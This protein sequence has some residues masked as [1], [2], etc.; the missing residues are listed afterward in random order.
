MPIWIKALFVSII[1]LMANLQIK[2]YVLLSSNNAIKKINCSGNDKCRVELNNELSYLAKI[3][4]ADWLLNYFAVF[5]LQ[6]NTKRFN[7][8]IAKDAMSQEQFYTLSLYLRSL[9]SKR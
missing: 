1:I 9:K 8:I 6:S 4:S 7:L 3:I 2:Q 5:V